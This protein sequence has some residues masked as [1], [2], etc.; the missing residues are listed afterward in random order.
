[1]NHKLLFLIACLIAP[2]LM[3]AQK[4]VEITPFGGYVFASR[5][6]GADGYVR[7][8]DNAQYG[9]ML[10]VGV[11]RVFDLDLIYNR[12]DTKAQV[13]LTSYPYQES[14]LSINYMNIGFTKNFRVNPTVSPF[15][16]FSMGACLMAP[17]NG[18]SYDY[19]FFD[20]GLSGGAKVYFGKHFGL[21]LQAQ[22]YVPMQAAG[23]TFYFGTGGYSS[24]VSVYST[25]IQFG[26]TGGL[27]FRLGHVPDANST[28][29]RY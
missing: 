8:V 28:R 2:L 18:N 4:T 5:M 15:I 16:G 25:M 10:S 27:I 1:M 17:K 13:N 22:M 12:I 6:S 20:V 23:Y 9:G 24:G 3:Q 21:R 19:W 29:V 26:F 11:S 7:F 14:P